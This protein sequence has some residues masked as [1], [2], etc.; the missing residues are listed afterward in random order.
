MVEKTNDEL[1][2]E[3]AEMERMEAEKAANP[4]ADGEEKKD[5]PYADIPENPSKFFNFTFSPPCLHLFSTL[6]PPCLHLD[7]SL[8]QT[9]ILSNQQQHL[10]RVA[11]I[12]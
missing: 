11:K 10:K 6:S 2:N 4:S 12:K 9:S 1:A 5:N 7:F 8:W 3:L